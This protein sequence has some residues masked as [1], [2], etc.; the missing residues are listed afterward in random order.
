M[1]PTLLPFE[2]RRYVIVLN[3]LWIAVVDDFK[4]S[5][6]ATRSLFNIILRCFGGVLEMSIAKIV[7]LDMKDEHTTAYTA[8]KRDHAV[9]VF[10]LDPV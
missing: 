7:K 9:L 4:R 3:G 6:K 10:A 2:K 5:S 8:M 1:D